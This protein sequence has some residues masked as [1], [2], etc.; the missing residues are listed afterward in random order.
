MK[1]I[2]GVADV[3]RVVFRTVTDSADEE[4]AAW[5]LQARQQAAALLI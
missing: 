3:R 2:V 1:L 4:R 5:L